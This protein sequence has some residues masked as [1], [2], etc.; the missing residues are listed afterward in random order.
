[1]A[2]FLSRLLCGVGRVGCS[3]ETNHIYY[4]PK[5]W[6]PNDQIRTAARTKVNPGYLGCPLDRLRAFLGFGRGG[7]GVV[8]RANWLMAVDQFIAIQPHR[9][10][11]TGSIPTP[12]FRSCLKPDEQLLEKPLAQR[13]AIVLVF[14]QKAAKAPRRMGHPVRSTA[15]SSKLICLG[16]NPRG[17]LCACTT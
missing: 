17:D 1:M 8:G 9:S 3:G 7:D 12:Q 10:L 15:E 5:V 16:E 11:C 4:F 6:N 2:T 14:C 13:A